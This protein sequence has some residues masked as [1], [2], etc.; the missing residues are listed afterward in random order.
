MKFTFPKD[1]L[2]GCA[3]SACQIESGCNEGGKG[4]D[5]GEHFFNIYPEK[6]QGGDPNKSADFYHKYP[7]DIKMM[8]EL[9]LR[10][11]RFS[12]SWS[13]IFPN[14]PDE[15]CQAGIDYYSDMIDKLR[16]AGIVTFFDLFH[17]DLPY[18]VIEMGGILDRRFIDWFTKYAETCFKALG[19]RVDYWCTV[20]EPS[21]N[22]F[23]SYAYGSNAPFLKDMN[24][25]FKAS[26]NMLLAHYK[27]LKIYKSLGFKGK[28]GAVIHH[29]PCYSLTMDERDRRASEVREAY[30]SGLWLDPMLK[31]HY[32]KILM[33]IP[34]ITEKLPEGYEKELKDNFIEN[35]YIAI[36]YYSP[37]YTKYIENH[38]QNYNEELNYEPISNPKLSSDDYG[39]KCYPNGLYDLVMDLAERYPGKDIIITENGIGI[40]KWGNYE[41][42]LEDDYRI[43][44]LREHLLAASRACK[45]GAPLK[46]YF[47]WSIMDTNEL[48]AGGYQFMFGMTQV[49]YDKENLE[50]V[51]RKSWYYYQQVIKNNE[52]Y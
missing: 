38:G 43:D 5:V 49:R 2:F 33:D 9:G 46:G 18:W 30:Y 17:C 16:E 39:F 21:I 8:K 25:A 31:G 32:P 24:L 47:H 51:P 34:Y 50:R 12:I 22:V 15:V 13:R 48:Y 14:G 52:V 41:E 19:D 37:G 27:T 35:D 28:I 4:E 23:A 36:N 44:Y 26:H 11:F 20:N 29:V 7:E 6:F 3:C 40:K 10:A 45:A 42:E 1:F